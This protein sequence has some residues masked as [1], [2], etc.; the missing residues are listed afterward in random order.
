MANGAHG[1]RERQFMVNIFIHY[2]NSSLKDAEYFKEIEKRLIILCNKQVIATY[3]HTG[4]IEAGDDIDAV[5]QQQ[6][7]LAQVV[8]LL[9]SPDYFS[10]G[11]CRNRHAFIL[12]RKAQDAL[13]IVPILLRPINLDGTDIVGFSA[14]PK[15]SEGE[16]F[17]SRWADLD[18]AYLHIELEMKRLAT[19]V[20][21]QKSNSHREILLRNALLR[22]NFSKE[23]PSYITYSSSERKVYAVLLQGEPQSSQS[24]LLQRLFGESKSK[25]PKVIS[26]KLDSAGHSP[27]LDDLWTMVGENFNMAIPNATL[28]CSA[29]TNA[30]VLD[31]EVI[32]RFDPVERYHLKEVQAFWT[33]LLRQLS[34]HKAYWKKPLHFYVVDRSA[35]K[36]WNADQLCCDSLL[37]P[38]DVLHLQIA[39]ITKPEFVN[40]LF[41]E[42]NAW[43]DDPQLAKIWENRDQIM[44]SEEGYVGDV[45]GKI[46][47]ICE[48]TPTIIH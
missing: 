36:E 41:A 42:K 45:V 44:P 38:G 32:I 31:T 43:S 4:L 9:I 23:I 16:V 15:A 27:S 33:E 8:L 3:W 26:I 22:F 10:D 46:C 5:I 21:S 48:V 29:L 34:P 17:L 24:L 37:S 30:M 2:N 39:K 6:L 25:N 40:W 47:E 13:C 1:I 12:K 18:E 14:L 19:E 28:V 11:D 7:G 20:L 35:A